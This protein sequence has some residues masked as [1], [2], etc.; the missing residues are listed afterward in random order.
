MDVDSIKRVA[1][2]TGGAGNIGPHIVKSLH[3]NG[4]EVYVILKPGTIHDPSINELRSIDSVHFVECDILN[5]GDLLTFSAKLKKRGRLDA[6]IANAGIDTP[7]PGQSA[8][9]TIEREVVSNPCESSYEFSRVVDVNLCGTF[10]TLVAFEDLLKVHGGSVVL[11]GSLYSMTSPDP[12]LYDHIKPKFVKSPAYAA[13]KAGVAQL[14]KFFAVHWGRY[15]I[16]VNTISPGGI[17]GNQ[18]RL[19]VRKYT[20]RVPMGRM[21]NCADVCNAVLFLIS[22][23]SR[24][25]TG[26][27]LPVD[28]GFLSL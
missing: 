3:D 21:C 2:V 1:L 8:T 25:I 18:D 7:P 4:M 17:L 5:I 10:N 13:S 28:G 11:I 27:N 16:N 26:I 19:F 9:R 12:S 23:D 24:Y 20:D 6:V 15:K 14:G 22:E